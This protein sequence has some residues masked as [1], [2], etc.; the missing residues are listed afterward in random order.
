MSCCFCVFH[1]KCV[2]HQNTNVDY[3]NEVL[4]ETVD[5]DDKQ[6]LPDDWEEGLTFT[7][8]SS[9][10]YF[11]IQKSSQFSFFSSIVLRVSVSDMCLCSGNFHPVNVFPGFSLVCVGFCFFNANRLILL[12]ST[13]SLNIELTYLFFDVFYW[14]LYESMNTYD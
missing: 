11:S 13:F 14:N 9:R 1:H 12:S 4:N 10:K 7:A 6:N 5:D 3:I 2:S 8:K